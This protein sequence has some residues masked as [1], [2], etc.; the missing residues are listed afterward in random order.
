MQ[1]LSD[2]AIKTQYAENKYRFNDGNEL[3]NKEFS[4]GTGIEMYDANFRNYDPQLG[5]FWQIDPL[6]ELN[7]G[8]S[9]YSF[10]NDNP[11]LLNDPTGLTISDSS[12]PQKLEEV[13]VTAALPNKTDHTPDVAA[14]AG[15][16]PSS[17]EAPIKT[18]VSTPYKLDSFP[19]VV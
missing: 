7:E 2:K 10:A 12:H 4:D 3:Q 5:R 13:I 9:P 8:W 1:G 16:A 17:A 19:K 6:G 11:V 15:P 18:S 14:A